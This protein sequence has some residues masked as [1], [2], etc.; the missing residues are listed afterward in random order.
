[1][2]QPYL[3]ELPADVQARGYRQ[4][5]PYHYEQ[6]FSSASTGFVGTALDFVKAGLGYA[7]IQIDKFTRRTI[8]I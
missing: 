8:K 3:I 5:R 6:V 7:Y 1:M 2:Y 4:V